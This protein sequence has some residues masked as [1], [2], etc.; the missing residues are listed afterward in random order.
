MYHAVE[1]GRGTLDVL[2]TDERHVVGYAFA[3]DAGSPIEAGNRVLDFLTHPDHLDHAS[4]LLDA[5]CEHTGARSLRCYLPRTDTRK[6][7]LLTG[8]GFREEQAFAGYCATS[9]GPVDL[10][11]MA[12]K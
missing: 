6:M 12:A 7:E 4:G 11:V 3:F 8:A 2:E 9:D 10:V 5:T 1:D